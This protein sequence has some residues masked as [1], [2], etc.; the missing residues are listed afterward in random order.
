MCYAILSLKFIQNN[1][2]SARI[3]H[4][5]QIGSEVPI[6]ASFSPG[7]AFLRR[8]AALGGL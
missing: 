6:C 8:K 5:S 2:I 1:H 3:P 4:Q 7:E